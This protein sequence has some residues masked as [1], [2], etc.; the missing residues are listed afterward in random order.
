MNIKRVYLKFT[1]RVNT[2]SSNH[3]QS[4]GGLRQFVDCINEAQ[5]SLLTEALSVDEATDDIQELLQVYAD[6]KELNG[7]S[8][9]KYNDFKLPEDFEHY[10]GVWATGKFGDCTLDIDV[11]LRRLGEASILYNDEMYEPS[12][13]WQETF[14]T[15]IGDKLR[16]YTKGFTVKVTLDYYRT[17]R[18]IDIEGYNVDGV[19]SQNIDPEL[20]GRHLERLIDR[21]AR[22]HLRDVSDP[23]V[24]SF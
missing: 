17:P 12:L 20:K 4:V 9:L 7:I 21:A 13:E 2:L 22:I 3:G 8:H 23:R 6:S 16:V 1:D 11:Q 14:A 5:Y 10:K 18:F 15:L 24:N 19:N